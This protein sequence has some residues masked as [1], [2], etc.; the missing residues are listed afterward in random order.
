MRDRN[1]RLG[2]EAELTVRD[3]YR[4]ILRGYF[5]A[6]MLYYG[7][8][9][10]LNFIGPDWPG[11]IAL[12]TMTLISV[13]IAM[14]GVYFMRKAEPAH[15]VDGLLLLMNVSVV[16]NIVVA[17]NVSFAPEKLTYFIIAAVSFSLGSVNF[18]QSLIS[19]GVMAVGMLT[20]A[21]QLDE[22]TLWL[23]CFLTFAAVIAASSIALL[24]RKAIRKI[25][26]A[27]VQ[28]EDELEN[29]NALSEELREQSLSDSLTKL[30]NRRA[31]FARLKKANREWAAAGDETGNGMDVWLVLMDLDGF[32]AVNDIHGHLVGDQLLQE[33]AV[34]LQRAADDKM[35][36]SRM[37]G[38]EFNLICL[39]VTDPAEVIGRCERLLTE[40]SQ[41]YLINERTIAISC[42]LGVTLVEQGRS[43]RSQISHADYALMV[44]KKKGKNQLVLFNEEHA[45]AAHAR[46][47]VEDALRKADLAKE[48]NLVFQPQFRLGSKTVVRAEVLVRWHSPAIG[49]VSPDGFIQIAEESGLITGVTLMVVQKALEELTSWPHAVPLSINLSSYDL[50]SNPTIDQIIS[51]V[52]EHGVDPSLIEFEVTETAMMADIAK[53]TANLDRLQEIGFPIALDDFG[54]G[55]SNFSYLRSLPIQKL[56]VDK[57]FVENPGDPMA[58][59]VL[60]SLVGMARVL[61]VHC[62]LEGVEDEVGLLM[63]KRAGAES[64]QGY[65]F[66]KPMTSE[67]LM[68]SIDSAGDNDGSDRCADASDVSRAS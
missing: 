5:C 38:D 52:K 68:R 33:V 35:F 4:P 57:S 7:A 9:L 24:M 34:R 37:G 50:I 63:A 16:L 54:T 26:D 11:F 15:R 49:H 62:L 29:A 51:L 44:A 58:E 14:F 30:P 45:Q 12:Q 53:A 36:I 56:K 10:P 13:S 8:M 40:I 22:N 47:R 31:F 55:Y 23:Y 48:L 43:F 27:K 19:Q 46:F 42:S 6:W 59:K 66:G 18:K 1:Q 39:G 28:A 20:F 41:P 67:N 65:L 21:P 17:L 61:G 25:A 3:I 60:A 32:K 64:V 2:K